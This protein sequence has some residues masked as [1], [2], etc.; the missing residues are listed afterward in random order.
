MSGGERISGGG[1]LEAV[2]DTPEPTVRPW[3]L[4]TRSRGSLEAPSG[5]RFV[6]DVAS[7]Q[8]RSFGLIVAIF[9]ALLAIALAASWAAIE[10]VNTTRAYAT[11]EGRYSK[12]Q[13]IAVLNLYRYAYSGRESDYAEFLK[14]T[15][16]PM[17][18][19]NGRLAMERSPPDLAAARAGILAG[20]NHADDIDGIIRMFLWFSWWQPFAAAVEDWREGDR[21]VAQ[22]IELGQ[23]LHGLV[24]GSTL[25]IDSREVLLGMIDR[26]DDRLTQLENTF[27]THMGEAARMATTLV[28]IGLGATTVLLWTVGM[29][30]ASRL[31]RQQLALDRQLSSS[32]E[33]FRDYTE[34][35]SDWYW[36]TDAAGRMIY[37][38]ERFVAV[39]SAAAQT[40]LHG[41][42]QEYIRAHADDAD[43]RDYAETIAAR[44]PFRSLRVRYEKADGSTGFWSLSGKPRFAIDGRFLGYRGVGT[45]VTSIVRDGLMLR[46]AKER[47]ELA[48]SAKSDFLANMSHELRTPLNAILGFSEIMSKRLFGGEALERYLDYARDI[49]VSGRH[50]LSIIDDILDLSKVES[51]R[52]ELSRSEVAL[53]D[54][55]DAALALFGD[56]FE[57]AG[58]AVQVALPEP[59]PQLWAD[60][61]KLKQVLI[62]I[63]SNALK[64]TPQGGRVTL[65]A[66]AEPDGSLSVSIS[67]TG[68]G[69]AP[70]HIDTVLAPFGQ[71]ESAFSRRHHGTG[72]GLPLAKALMELHGGSL[73][74]ESAQGAGTVVTLWLPAN[75]V[76]ARA[77][78]GGA[79]RR[80]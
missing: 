24:S 47:A 23:N 53:V 40:R 1:R 9:I 3:R 39:A 58:I 20:E 63:L 7:R 74:L 72:L 78:L 30:F 77:P 62:N 28:I 16:V 42:S 71:V 38:S 6:P 61:R 64:F 2:A 27:S 49:H 29:V 22:L 36:E 69:I 35:A 73:R 76:H 75:C 50:L 4:F 25:D 68:I 17:G 57:A 67:D 54:V 15:A 52:S 11:G 70:D 51:G 8:I 41:D 5:A 60:E 56:R 80:G 18:D 33:R 59:T 66:A 79:S 21:L 34:V 37:M 48:N 31:F 10:L 46:E 14:A 45:D 13:K 12:A 32:E 19:H 44:L 26:I 65:A 43:F 55:V